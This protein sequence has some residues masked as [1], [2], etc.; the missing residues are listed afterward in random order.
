[1][2]NNGNN[3]KSSSMAIGVISYA[4][5]V[6]IVVIFFTISANSNGGS[7]AK[8]VNTSESVTEVADNESNDTYSSDLDVD[9]DD[10][11]DEEEVTEAE[12]E[13]EP[14]DEEEAT[15]AE[16][17]PADDEETEDATEAEDEEGIVE[18]P[19][20]KN[21][22]SKLERFKPTEDYDFFKLWCSDC[23]AD[24]EDGAISVDDIDFD[25]DVDCDGCEETFSKH[26]DKNSIKNNGLCPDCYDSYQ[27]I[28]E[29][30]GTDDL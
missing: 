19:N 16:D 14:A 13:D 4:I 22:V 21:M 28:M 26:T 7:P 10:D 15:E 20:C 12:V 29:E 9:T 18:C 24:V 11:S 3:G 30:N 6:A 23:R 17:V 25:S 2:S 1:M 8:P 5:I 27:T